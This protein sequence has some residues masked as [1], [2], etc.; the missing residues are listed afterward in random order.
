M[1]SPAASGSTVS[2]RRLLRASVAGA[3]LLP[4]ASIE[5]SGV[6]RLGPNAMGNPTASLGDEARAYQRVD[7]SPAAWRT[8]ILTSPDE[9]RPGARRPTQTEID[10]LLQ[11]QAERDEAHRAGRGSGDSRPAV[12]PW[13]EVANAAWIEF[14]LSPLRQGRANGILQTAMYDAVIAAYDAQE[15]YPCAAPGG[16]RPPDH[17]TG[18]DRRRPAPASPRPRPPWPVPP[19]P[20]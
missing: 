8:W 14:R 19:L 7:G 13:T 18:G 4:L 17:P 10:E 5:T 16:A 3:A 1:T 12:L 20:C 11:L 2:R 9:L 15:A 6:A